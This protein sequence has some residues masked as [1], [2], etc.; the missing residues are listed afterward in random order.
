MK[1]MDN[2]QFFVEKLHIRF[3]DVNSVHGKPFALGLTLNHIHVESANANWKPSFNAVGESVKHKVRSDAH[4]S[5]TQLITLKSAAVYFNTR[6]E[7][8]APITWRT[9]QEFCNKMEEQV[10]L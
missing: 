9:D 2:L 7:N 6:K 4:R 10:D 8:A 5:H 1:V 3:E